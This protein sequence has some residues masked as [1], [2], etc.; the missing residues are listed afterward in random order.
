MKFVLQL[1]IPR[2]SHRRSINPLCIRRIPFA[3]YYEASTIL[4]S[5][6]WGLSNKVD[7]LYQVAASNKA[8][9]ISITETWLSHLVPIR[10]SPLLVIYYREMQEKSDWRG[11]VHVLSTANSVVVNVILREHIQRKTDRFL[12]VHP[13]AMVT[14]VGDFNPT[15]TGLPPYSICIPNHLKQLV[16]FNTRDT[17]IL[18]WFCANRPHIFNLQML[19]KL[20]SSEHY[21]ILARPKV[22]PP[23]KKDSVRNVKT[24]QFG[25][26]NWGDFGS[27]ITPRDWS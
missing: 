17:G 10:L 19:A 21:T 1:G 11:C 25:A 24:K 13:N 12:V 7:E 20:G 22:R 27:W 15:S 16:K 3:K 23:S 14:F 9:I 4:V 2:R 8:N 5:N 26:C 18:D 6:I